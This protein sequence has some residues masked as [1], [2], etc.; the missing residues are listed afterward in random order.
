MH[1]R[2]P[3]LEAARSRSRLPFPGSIPT[4]S[5]WLLHD[6]ARG[7]LLPVGEALLL[8]V[9]ETYYPD[10]TPDKVTKEVMGMSSMWYGLYRGDQCDVD[11]RSSVT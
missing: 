3:A 5:H 8:V 9:D 1:T 7:H 2:L 6:R 10:R 4:H 11:R